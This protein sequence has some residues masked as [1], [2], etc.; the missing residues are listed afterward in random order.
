MQ[1]VDIQVFEAFIP[2]R[3]LAGERPHQQCFQTG[4][5]RTVNFVNYSSVLNKGAIW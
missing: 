1:Y 3:I 2:Q 5:D 4:L